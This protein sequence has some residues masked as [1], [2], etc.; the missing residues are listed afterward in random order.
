MKEQFAASSKLKSPIFESKHVHKINGCL[1]IEIVWKR[2]LV[3]EGQ[4]SHEPV[5]DKSDK[6]MATI[7]LEGVILQQETKIL[8]KFFDVVLTTFVSKLV[9]DLSKVPAISQRGIDAL[10]RLRKKSKKRGC[11]LEIHG[12]HPNV[13]LILE[14]LG[15]SKAFVLR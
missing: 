14:D 5:A 2:V 9:L 15:L 13:R 4:Q 11:E 6:K 10:L 8:Q 12:I 1:R 3:N 7:V